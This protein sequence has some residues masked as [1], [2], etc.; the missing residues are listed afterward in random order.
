MYQKSKIYISIP[1]SD[2]TAISLLEAIANNCVCFVSNLPA[3]SEHILD[4]INGFI[5]PN[6]DIIDFEKYKL[7][8]NKILESVNNIRKESYLR[9]YNKKIFLEI[10]DELLNG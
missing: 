8:D 7:I 2:A 4:K 10:Y 6:L 3:N 1:S 5:E 9:G